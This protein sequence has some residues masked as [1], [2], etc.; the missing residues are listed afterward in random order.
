MKLRNLFLATLAA[1]AITSCS[2]ENDPTDNG[3]IA[4]KAI[5]NF[6]IAL[7]NSGLT[8]ADATDPGTAQEQKVNDITLVLEYPSGTKTFEKTYPVSDFDVV[9]NVYS[10]KKGTAVNPG[11]ANLFVYVNSNGAPQETTVETTVGTG[12]GNY[13]STTGEGNFFMSGKSD[14]VF[15]IV[16]NQTNTAPTIKVDRIAVKL[17]E[18]TP[19]Y[20]FTPTALSI[21]KDDA[22]EMTITL[23][24]YAYSNLNKKSNALA[25]TKYY[26]AGDFFNAFVEN[27]ETKLWD[28]FATTYPMGNNVT[29]CFENGT[30]EPTKIYYKA[31]VTITDVAEGANFYIYDNTLYKNFDLLNNKFGGSLSDADGYN[32]SDDSTNAEFAA[33]GVRKY[34]AGICYYPAVISEIG[35]DR[36]NWY[37]IKV[38]GIKDLG[39][40]EIDTPPPG[41]P[42]L[43]I[44][45]VKVNPWNV[46]NKDIEL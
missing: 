30:T 17:D 42:T 22:T 41:N 15:S 21:T 10:L 34:T 44:F 8:R 13:A 45:S 43:L 27:R 33:V 39:L 24:D 12:L 19:E 25:G 2:N 5:F 1:M 26:K 40:P 29:Y 16:A 18:I 20:T 3:E 46:W 7:P 31:N 37:K 35:I 9:E 4:E 23:T 36:N 11:N 32:L 38:T 14:E 28:T 6:S